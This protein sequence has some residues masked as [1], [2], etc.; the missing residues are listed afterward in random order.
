[1]DAGIA[2]TILF[3]YPVMVTLIL[4]I[5]FKEKIRPLTLCCLFLALA[6]IGL[7]CKNGSGA[8][9]SRVGLGLTMV[10]ALS[11]ALYIIAVNRNR[12]LKTMPT[13]KLTFYT[14]FVSSCIFFCMTRFGSELTFPEHGYQWTL[15]LCLSLFPTVISFL[16]T[17]Q[18]IHFIGPTPTAILGA[19]EPVTAVFFGVLLFDESLSPRILTGIVLIIAAVTMIVAESGISDYLVRFRKLFPK[20][21]RRKF[22]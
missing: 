14:L 12:R 2:S 10:S 21:P 3:V 7:L 9:I 8:V 13:V 19:L 16:S 5:F 1:M 15:L 11:Y 4:G 20:L 6:G 17:T 18:A 22:R